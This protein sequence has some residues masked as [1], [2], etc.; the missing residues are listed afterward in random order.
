MGW[1]I[2]FP[3]IKSAR[4]LKFGKLAQS[5]TSVDC[6]KTTTIQKNIENPDQQ[7]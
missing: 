3:E 1:D 7:H 5:T 6:N 4:L 2:L